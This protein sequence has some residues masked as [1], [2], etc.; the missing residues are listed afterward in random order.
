MARNTQ[1]LDVA[2]TQPWHDSAHGELLRYR[3]EQFPALHEIAI[4]R[5]RT[6]RQTRDFGLRGLL[7]GVEMA[8]AA[9]G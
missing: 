8:V 6:P 9:R 2:G 5:T 1:A 7:D 3:E 4:G